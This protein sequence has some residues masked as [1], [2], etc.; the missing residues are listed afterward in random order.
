M[1]RLAIIQIVMVDI[2]GVPTGGTVALR[3]VER[4]MG[5]GHPVAVAIKAVL[6]CVVI[7]G[8]VVPPGGGMTL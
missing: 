8:D 6:S 2:N 4:I 7:K 1:A 3:A 5:I